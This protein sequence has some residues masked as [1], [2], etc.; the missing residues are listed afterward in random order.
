MDPL[1]LAASRRRGPTNTRPNVDSLILREVQAPARPMCRPRGKLRCP[2]SLC[3][4]AIT[5]ASQLQ[6]HLQ[7]AEARQQRTTRQCI[8]AKVR[9]DGH[10]PPGHTAPATHRRRYAGDGL[11][12]QGGGAQPQQERTSTENWGRQHHCDK[13]SSAVRWG[14]RPAPRCQ[15]ATRG[16]LGP[17]SQHLAPPHRP[18]SQ[19]ARPHPSA[20]K[21]R[22]PQ[23]LY[24]LL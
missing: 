17:A 9:M 24:L 18:A 13:T 3:W 14:Q 23:L 19:P 8:R 10:A 15:K 4:A 6:V 16:A 11:R 7:G 21:Q 12:L 22:Q 2:L 20:T 5:W 1:P